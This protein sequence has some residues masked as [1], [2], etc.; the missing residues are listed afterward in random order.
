ML[1]GYGVYDTTKGAIEA[2]TH[3]I[4]REFGPRGITSTRSRPARPRPRVT[5][6]NVR[7]NGG[8]V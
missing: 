1:P 8:T 7:V 4:A 5:A 6:Q 2:L 3:V